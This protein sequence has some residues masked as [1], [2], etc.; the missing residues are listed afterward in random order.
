MDSVRQGR[1]DMLLLEYASRRTL[2]AD[3][4]LITLAAAILL[5]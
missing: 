1:R 2:V 5:L 3:L 4:S